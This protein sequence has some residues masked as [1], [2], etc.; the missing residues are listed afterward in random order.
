MERIT[1]AIYANDPEG[2]AMSNTISVHL[3]RIRQKLHGARIVA[4]RGP[5]STYRLIKD[6]QA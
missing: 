4:S 5:G 2:G 6:P 3:V 1:N